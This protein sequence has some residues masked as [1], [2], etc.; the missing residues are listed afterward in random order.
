MVRALLQGTKTQTRRVIKPQPDFLYESPWNEPVCNTKD[1]KYE[2]GSLLWVRETFVIESTYE[3]HGDHKS[4]KD[5]RPIKEVKDDFDGYY[6]LIPHYRATEPEPN[7]VPSH[8]E[9]RDEWDDS[10]VW[11]PSIYMPRWASRLT[12]R[13]TNVRAERVQ[14]IKPDE[15][16][17]EGVNGAICCRFL[18]SSPTANNLREAEIHGFSGFWNSI[19]EKRGYGWETNPWVWCLTFEVIHQ[20]IDNFI[21]GLGS[22][23]AA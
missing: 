13:L 7:I 11:S 12:L 18:E 20:N 19:N 1:C 5:G 23:S 22:Y 16:I 9:S 15:A 4:P 17:A 3:Y 21:A 10:T 14:D 2:I 8:S 6:C